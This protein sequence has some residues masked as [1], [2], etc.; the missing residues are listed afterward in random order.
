MSKARRATRKALDRVTWRAWF[1]ANLGND[2]QF[3]KS[4]LSIRLLERRLKKGPRL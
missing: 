4:M 3:H 1:A 2:H